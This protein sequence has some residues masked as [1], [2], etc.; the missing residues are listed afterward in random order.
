MFG[1]SRTLVIGVGNMVFIF[2]ADV[3]TARGRERGLHKAKKGLLYAVRGSGDTAAVGF[4]LLAGIIVC[5]MKRGCRD[6]F[7]RYM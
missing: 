2:L 3:L 4:V 7:L 1:V 5:W 6:L